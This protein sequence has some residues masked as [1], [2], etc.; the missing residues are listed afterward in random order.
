MKKRTK[1]VF[2]MQYLLILLLVCAFGCDR[3]DKSMREYDEVAVASPLIA[4]EEDLAQFNPSMNDVM[5]TM[6]NEE[7]MPSTQMP[8]FLESSKANVSLSWQRPS[9]WIEAPGEGMR[10][11][12]FRSNENPIECSIVSLGG[13]AGG[14]EANFKRWL[15]QL[16]IDLDEASL[17]EFIDSQEKIQTSEKISMTVANFTSLQKD[18]PPQTP[19]MIATILETEGKTIFI[20]MTGSKG[21]CLKQY[22]A[23]KSLCRSIKIEH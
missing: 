16:G 23:F 11:V 2:L 3:A 19:S 8:Q 4:V 7:L 12:T 6:K 9:G 5:N 10:V 1:M 20:K 13:P 22:E 15:G 14:L 21:D 18:L 17:K